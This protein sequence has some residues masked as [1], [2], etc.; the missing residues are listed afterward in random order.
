MSRRAS[1]AFQD[2]VI[3]ELF[4]FGIIYYL[5]TCYLMVIEPFMATGHVLRSKGVDRG[6]KD[7]ALHK[8]RWPQCYGGTFR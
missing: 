3:W 2:Q 1:V 4:Q 6:R 8:W 5:M 7:E